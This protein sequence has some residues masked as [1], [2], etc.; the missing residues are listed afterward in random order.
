MRSTFEQYEEII[1]LLRVI[2]EE[3]PES[4]EVTTRPIPEAEVAS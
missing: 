3:E 1:R 4:S 2:A